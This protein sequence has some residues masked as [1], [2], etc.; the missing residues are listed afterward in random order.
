MR[1]LYVDRSPETI[2]RKMYRAEERVITHNHF[3]KKP[4]HIYQ[5][6]HFTNICI[7]YVPS[8]VLSTENRAQKEKRKF[9]KNLENLEG[10]GY[11]LKDSS[12]QVH[13]RVESS[14][15]DG[16]GVA[17]EAGTKQDSVTLQNQRK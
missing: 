5:Y 13:I 6:S 16:K 7:Y 9:L 1:K 15:R 17:S 10:S 11:N 12:I 3:S 8:S 4:G 2:Q 14:K